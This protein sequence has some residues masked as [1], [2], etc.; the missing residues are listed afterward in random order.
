MEKKISYDELLL[1]NKLLIKKCIEHKINI[2]DILI[3][4]LNSNETSQS[5]LYKNEFL[6][7]EI[8]SQVFEK[9]PVGIFIFDKNS[10]ITSSN[11]KFAEII[12]GTKE[13][14]ISLNILN[15]IKNE[16]VKAAISSCLSNKTT[17]Y[18]GDYISSSFGK[19][20]YIKLLLSPL[21]NYE[22]EVI[23][24]IGLVED[25]TF[26]K[27]YEDDLIQ[28][29]AQ[30][31]ALLDNIPALA[32]LKNKEGE[33]LAANHS[34]AEVCNKKFKDIIGKTDLDIWYKEL[35]DKVIY[36]DLKVISERRTINNEI[37]FRNNDGKD[38]YLEVYKT[39]V[40]DNNNQIIGTAGFATDI[41]QKK[42]H[43]KELKT[44]KLYFENL[45][46]N[47]PEA[48][49]I[50]DINSK[51]IR[52]NK[53]FTKLFQYEE[54]EILGRSIDEL[55][56]EESEVEFAHSITQQIKTGTDN[57]FETVRLRKDRTKIDVVILGVPIQLNDGSIVIYGIYQ[58]ISK[59][60]AEQK[61]LKI[62]KEKA[63]E[64]D[65]LKTNFLATMSHE[66]RTPLN[67]I[68]GFSEL[69]LTEDI[70]DDILDMVQS[71][72]QSGNRLL[73][74]I[75]SILDISIL[76]SNKL[77]LQIK[78]EN[79]IDIINEKVSN[80]L[81]L[82]E[83]KK[84]ELNFEFKGTLI[85]HTDKK[86]FEIIINNLLDNAIKYTKTGKIEISLTKEGN[87]KKNY[88][89]ITVKDTGIGIAKENYEKIFRYFSQVSEGYTRTYEG[90]GLGLSITKH[91]VDILNGEISVESELEI[92]S[93][94]TIK[95]P[96]KENDIFCI[97]NEESLL[98][99]RPLVL[100]VE[101]EKTN[102]EYVIL[103]LRKEYEVDLAETGLEAIEL[104]KQKEY[105]IILMDINLGL[106]INGITTTSEIRKNP[107]YENI[108][109]IA[110]TANAMIG[111]KEILLSSGLTDY[112]SKP[113]RRD[114]LLKTIKKNLFETEQDF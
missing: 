17:N 112:I 109:I 1:Q 23:G 99:A 68:L 95:I 107:Y 5:L 30:L 26:Q 102:A 7:N 36:E 76:E 43:E 55:I 34:F 91:Y 94:F 106:G 35:A 57:A 54:K 58:D 45:F 37:K 53:Q 29:K 69:L 9:S 62:A 100:L 85:V 25:H 74:T 73:N 47:S 97:E 48:I 114:A 75:N 72:H 111:Q 93:V 110:V 11:Y 38:F 20:T 60:K 42:Q 8:I 78:E 3:F 4:D 67:G 63:I 13:Q 12:G 71:I 87:F 28:T 44:E 51:V 89:K 49:I 103:S 41:S 113:F 15:T 61:E 108:P 32:W 21:T 2:D 81:P 77:N 10:V 39:P 16:N 59:Q 92:G 65:K 46:N 83:E 80:F 79:L 14:I 70:N 64:S 22:N 50:A 33:Y 27:N 105:H 104:S 86:I 19:Y 52:V 66:L 40:I 82:A 84:L 24:G 31:R 6:L 88:L 18:S 90:M 56:S 101:D 98:P 96:L